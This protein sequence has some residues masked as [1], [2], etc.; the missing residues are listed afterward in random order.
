MARLAA[1]AVEQVLELVRTAKL[2]KVRERSRG[3]IIWGRETC[4][5]RLV[6]IFTLWLGGGVLQTP[7]GCGASMQ[8]P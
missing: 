8:E 5:T 7:T 2:L 4:G 1:L 6:A 3:P